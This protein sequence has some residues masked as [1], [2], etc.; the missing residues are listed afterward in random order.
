MAEN[1]L[2]GSSIA[3][4]KGIELHRYLVSFTDS[5]GPRTVVHEFPK[6]DG[7]RIE[8]MGRRP[9]RTEFQLVFTGPNWIATLKQLVAAIDADASG[10]LVHPIYGQMQ[11]VCRYGKDAIGRIDEI[12]SLNDIPDPTAIPA[13]TKLLLPSA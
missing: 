3:S 1:L 9:H 6:R 7:A 4:F 12:L 10:L 2:T 8:V 11:V 13:G 5:R